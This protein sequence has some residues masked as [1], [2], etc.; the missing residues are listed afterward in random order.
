MV[1]KNKRIILVNP[2]LSVRRRYGKLGQAGSNE[3]PL[4]L[5]YLASIVRKAGFD[6]R[7]IDAQASGYELT[8]TLN[9]IKSFEPHYVGISAATMAISSASELARMIKISE[10]NIKIIIGGSHVSALP[11]ETLQECG[12]FDAGVIGEGEETLKELVLFLQNNLDLKEVKG[13]TIRREDNLIYRSSERMRIKNLDCLPMPAFELLPEIASSYRL[14]TQSLADKRS[15]S[16][17]TSRGCAGNCSFCDKKVFGNYISMHSAEYV[18]EM[19]HILNKKHKI[20]NIMF[21]DDDFLISKP[22][23]EKLIELINKKGLTIQWTA[24][25]RID[26]VDK[27]ILKIAKEGGC[28]QIAYGIESGSQGVLDFYK[29]GI[30]IEKIKDKIALTKSIGLKIKCF[31]M[32][33]NPREDKNSINQTIRLINNLDIDDISVTFFTPFPGSRIWPEIQHYGNFNKNWQKMSCFEVVFTPYRLDSLYLINTRKKI[34]RD[35]YFRPKIFFSYLT[36]I[37]SLA[38]LKELIF[39]FFCLIRYLFY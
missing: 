23:I 13:I 22:R 19:I 2:P 12:F 5:C 37:K 8:R 17:V 34:L 20:T 36:R 7:I 35:F 30:T 27:D 21:E 24:K 14:P 38:Q 4:G 3:P 1:E 11:S 29:K 18:L 28:W 25:T 16:L 33:G 39:S 31:F 9:I 15:F 10:S 26:A 32:L 6:V